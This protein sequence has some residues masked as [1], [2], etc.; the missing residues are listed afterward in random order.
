MLRGEGRVLP[1]A[2]ST[3]MGTG[4][5][6]CLSHAV[7]GFATKALFLAGYDTVRYPDIGDGWSAAEKHAAAVLDV[8]AFEPWFLLEGVVLALAG[9]QYLRTARHRRRWVGTLA[10]GTLL[11]VLFGVVLAVTGR[12]AALG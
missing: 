3:A 1:A 11:L 8:A 7:F 9:W 6:V 2:L 5:A 4:A 10:S 12:R